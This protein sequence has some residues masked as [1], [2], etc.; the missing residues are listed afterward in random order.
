MGARLRD[1]HDP[2]GL[3]ME[4]VAISQPGCQTCTSETDSV[5]DYNGRILKQVSGYDFWDNFLRKSYQRPGGRGTDHDCDT[6]R[7]E[8]FSGIGGESF[9][10]Y[11]DL[12]GTVCAQCR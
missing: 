3:M 10:K 2:Q 11:G 12:C 6:A 8:E 9:N 5:R 7:L 4:Y 1:Q